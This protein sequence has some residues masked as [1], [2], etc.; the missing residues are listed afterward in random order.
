MA[1]MAQ[2]YGGGGTGSAEDRSK[3][4]LSNFSTGLSSLTPASKVNR[5]FLLD[6]KLFLTPFDIKN[7]HQD[8]MVARQ[9]KAA[10]ISAVVTV[11]CR[12]TRRLKTSGTLSIALSAFPSQ[13]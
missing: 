3:I 13:C 10:T 6:V 8:M 11:G 7:R 12:E 5:M 9:K 4:A 1:A 2:M